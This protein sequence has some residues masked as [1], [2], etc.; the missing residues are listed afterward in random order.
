MST[1]LFNI[2]ADKKFKKTFTRNI[3]K[4]LFILKLNYVVITPNAESVFNIF[5]PKFARIK[6]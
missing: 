3:Y 4:I 6:C 2:K 5:P 1:R